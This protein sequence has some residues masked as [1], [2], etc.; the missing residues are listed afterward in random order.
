MNGFII[1][2]DL[3]GFS[4]LTEPEIRLFYGSLIPPLAKTVKPYKE[5][6]KALNTWGDAIVA[7]FENAQVAV[8]FAL[9]YRDFFREFNFEA[10]GM[11]QLL[12]RIACHFGEFEVFDDEV[13]GNTNI[14]GTN[15][16]AAARLE[17]VTRS[18]QIY[19]TKPFKEAIERLPQKLD[20]IVFDDLGIIPLAK[21]FGEI[22]VFR[23]HKTEEKQQIIDK[24][25]KIDLSWALP[26]ALKASKG[27]EDLIAFY[28][29]SPNKERLLN[30]ISQEN[31]DDNSGEFI[32]EIA[33]VCKDY[34]LYQEAINFIL[35]AEDYSLDVNGLKVYPYKHNQK[36]LKLKAN[37]LTR[38]GGF[39]EAANIVYGLWQSGM[40]DPDTLS[41]LA[42]QYKRRALSNGTEFSKD[43][44]NL[45]LLTRSKDLYL[46]AFRINIDDYYPAINVAYLYKMIG[47]LGSGKG[48]KLAAYIID[49]WGDREGKEWWLDST[50]AEA[51]LLLDD[52]EEFEI[53][54]LKAI[55]KYRPDYFERKAVS[56]QIQIYAI[57]TSTEAAVQQVITA[58]ERE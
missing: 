25:L 9:N 49:A 3:K 32:L 46:E 37:C 58:L 35:K 5:R 2:S 56:E 38:L 33:N 42:A 27:E 20:Y 57:V 41:M 17:P 4:K 55:D 43:N 22:E 16:N 24:I 26:Q 6:A 23:L 39:E 44:I 19:V 48:V 34:G 1:F 54:M 13:L 12:P 7:I 14:L 31:T 51:E 29:K 40:K 28:R 21:D 45:D 10:L 15:I 47:G 30:L 52:Y 18:G 36:L 11:R 8:D 50:L 53:K